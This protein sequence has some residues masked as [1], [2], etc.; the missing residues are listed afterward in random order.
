MD[1]LSSRE[2][3]I[4][5]FNGENIDRIATYD[6]IHNIDLI[7]HLANDKINSKNAEDLTCKAVNKIL[8]LVRHFGIPKDLEPRIIKDQDGYV[9]KKEWWTG[10][11]VSRPFNDLK[12]AKE[13]MEKDIERIY[14]CIDERKICRAALFHLNLF[15]ENFEYFEEVKENFKRITEKLNGTIMIAPES[16][17]P[18]VI[19]ET[20]FDFIWWTYLYNDYPELAT[21]Y[22]NAL[23]DYELAKID[24]FADLSITPIS[25]TSEPAGVNNNLIHS[26]DFNLKVVLPYVK[27]L[28]KQWKSHGYYHIYF[29]D[30]YKWP[31][32]DE[33]ISWDL[34]DAIDP[35]E[36]LAQMDV[37]KFREKYPNI[38]ICQPIDCQNL[39]YSG[40][41]DEVKNATLKAI[42]DT[43]GKKIIIGSTSEI[44]PN[45]LIDNALAMF[46]AA[47]DYKV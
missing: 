28:V 42:N 2:R 5:T 4:N 45:V 12:G 40:S 38:T 29:A 15:D 3:L 39:L 22:L 19:A 32:L 43:E 33:I 34:V 46:K 36:P 13:V 11:I 8:D 6:I 44:H 37:K 21:K 26:L 20:R 16:A 10:S 23:N 31:L 17:G 25:F 1:S 14:K 27:K 24:S 9:Y 18:L 7:E 35:F 47:R 41:P 30:G